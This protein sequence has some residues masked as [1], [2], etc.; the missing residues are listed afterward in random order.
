ML[1]QIAPLHTMALYKDDLSRDTHAL[2]E[3]LVSFQRQ[4]SYRLRGKL[5]LADL[6]GAGHRGGLARSRTVRDIP[7]P[8]EP[9]KEYRVDLR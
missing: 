7:P 2:V 3:V 5:N 8:G 4:A 9:I 6:D 1:P